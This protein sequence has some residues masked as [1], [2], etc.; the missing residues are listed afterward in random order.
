MADPA[1]NHTHTA[2]ALKREGKRHGKW[3][4]VGGARQDSNGVIHLFLDR[5]PIGGFN[6][7]AYWLRAALRRRCSN[8]NGRARLA[9]KNKGR[10]DAGR[11]PFP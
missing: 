9:I 5:L 10:S 6:G 8:P 7:Y 4:E 1:A 3:L 2:Y 11:K